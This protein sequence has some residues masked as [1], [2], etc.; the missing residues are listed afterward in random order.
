MSD[1]KSY[2]GAEITVTF[3]AAV[4]QHSGNC[5]RGLPEVFDVRRRPWISPDDAPAARVAE[6][7]ERCPSGA[8]RYV[9]RADAD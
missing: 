3:D 5:V 7:V 2:E 1:R 8:L 4:C 6:A 9:L